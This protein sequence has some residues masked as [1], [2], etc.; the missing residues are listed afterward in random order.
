MPPPKV[1][2]TL[3]RI[4]LPPASREH[5]LGDLHERYTSPQSYLADALAVLGPVII[6]RIRRTTDAQVFMM[7][8]LTVYLSFTAAAFVTGERSLLYGHPG[9]LLL[10]VPTTIAA[11]ALLLCNAYSDPQRT[12]VSKPILQSAGCISL[13][14][15]G[16]SL[17]ADMRASFAVPDR[18]VLYGGL[19]AML[20]LSPLR[21]LFP[22]IQ[23]ALRYARTGDRR[24]YP[25]PL[26]LHAGPVHRLHDALSGI[27]TAL[28]SNVVFAVLASVLAAA[29]IVAPLWRT[30]F[31]ASRFA[32]LL[33]RA[34]LI[35][36]LLVMYRIR[37]GE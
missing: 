4:L 19:L 34:G 8:T 5:V 2:E 11:V 21:M 22:P 10:A 15:L 17:A 28:K 20:L 18:T 36:V 26:F 16:Q 24:S 9:F 3:L 32:P 29:W 6:G 25:S 1:F 30:G 31:P 23:K 35:V 13:A 7:E 37:T 14:V 33:L 12:P 27:R